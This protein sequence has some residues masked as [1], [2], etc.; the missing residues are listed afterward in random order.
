MEVIFTDTVWKRRFSI[1]NSANVSTTTFLP[2][3]VGEENN[4]LDPWWQ[5]LL[6]A[7]MLT[8][9]SETNPER[10]FFF[11]NMGLIM[12]EWEVREE[13]NEQMNEQ[14]KEQTNK[15]TNERI[16]KEG[17]KEWKKENIRRN[18][19]TEWWTDGRTDRRTNKRTTYPK[20]N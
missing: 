11:Q 14:M 20:I 2:L 15:Q 7:T 18:G 1:N 19:L 6:H 8:P 4:T 5:I 12:K 13:M 10:L 3:K 9:V 16:G 17:M